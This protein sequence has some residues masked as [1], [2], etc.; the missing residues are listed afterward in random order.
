MLRLHLTHI[1]ICAIALRSMASHVRKMAST[2]G[3]LPTA[4]NAMRGS[5]SLSDQRQAMS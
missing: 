4:M 2:I 5:A 3:K 1:R